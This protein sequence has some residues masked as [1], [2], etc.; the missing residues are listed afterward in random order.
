VAGAFE[1]FNGFEGVRVSFTRGEQRSGFHRLRKRDEPG[2]V[3]GDIRWPRDGP[4]FRIRVNDERFHSSEDPD[5][6]ALVVVHRA[7]PGGMNGLKPDETS[8]LLSL[9]VAAFLCCHDEASDEKFSVVL[10]LQSRG[11]KSSC[12]K[13][14]RSEIGRNPLI[15]NWRLNNRSIPDLVIVRRPLLR[16]RDQME[17]HLS[18]PVQI[19]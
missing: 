5:H 3:F 18:C 11:I 17:L 9:K 15:A 14:D 1:V 13:H 2:I 10:E 16:S 6:V 12:L 8:S 4:L 7:P 19:T